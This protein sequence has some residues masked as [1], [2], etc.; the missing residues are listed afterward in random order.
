MRDENL[1]VFG[2]PL[3]VCSLDP[4]TGFRRDGCCTFDPTDSGKHIVCIVATA[5]FLEFSR[6]K[7]N[8]LTTP[9]PEYQFPGL[10]PG[11]RWCICA[12]RWKEA[13]LAGY[14]PQ[15]VLEACLISILDLVPFE[16]LLEF[17]KTE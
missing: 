15:V 14:A 9:R 12:L 17:K 16:W 1:N 7:G 3:I 13:Y 10:L 4:L 11:D 2:K 6:A 5:G 8:D